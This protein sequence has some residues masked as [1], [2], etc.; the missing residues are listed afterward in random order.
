MDR[1]GR[2]PRPRALIAAARA[3]AA[4]L[5]LAFALDPS[6]RHGWSA[7]YYTDVDRERVELTRTT[8]HRVAFPNMHRPF[9]RVVQGWPMDRLGVPE[10]LPDLDVE[11]TADV[12]VPR[13]RRVLL[14]VESPNRTTLTVDGEV[15]ADQRFA[16]GRHRVEVRWQAPPVSTRAAA[17]RVRLRLLWGAHEDGLE[18]V[19]ASAIRPARGAWPPLRVALWISAL[20]G[21]LLWAALVAW[22]LWPGPG[23][24]EARRLAVLA[25]VG[26][27]VL[28]VAFRAFDYQVMPEFRDNADELF[29]TWNGFSLLTEGVPRGWSL[30]PGSYGPAVER[31]PVRFFG[32]ERTV[33]SPY[34]EHPPLLHVLVGAAAL[35]GG[36][37]HFLEAKLAHT[38]LVAIAMSALTL[39]LLVV[40]GRRLSPRGPAPY[41]AG[42]LYAVLPPIALQG[43]VVKEE[44]LLAPLCLAALLFFLRWRDDGRHRVDLVAA[45]ALMGLGILGKVPAV[46]WV[47]ALAMLV[48]AEGRMGPA[49]V[50]GGVGL[51]VATLWPLFGLLIDGPV[52][53]ETQRLQGGRPTHWNLFPRWFHVSLINHNLVGRGWIQFLWLGYVAGVARRGWRDGAV[54]TVPLVTYL[55]AI[56]VGAG[57]WTF[58]WYIAPLYP[59]LCLGAGMFLAELWER[60]TLLAGFLFVALAVFYALNFLVD[61]HW[62]KQPPA[63]PVLR[64]TIS[65]A[66]FA[67]FAP[68]ALVQVW[69]RHTLPLWLARTAT[70]ASLALLVVASGLFVARYDVVFETH[71]NFDRDSYFDR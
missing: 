23:R 68:Y 3:A 64:R 30:W 37:D 28:G 9:A 27:L 31:T 51:A 16:P 50:A 33:I 45:A 29:A 46:V 55:A 43:R 47:P 63:W 49:W 65:L 14:R 11:L 21:A 6:L 40:L 13:D 26:L 59:L 34:F 54:L 41:L 56:S 36:A 18:A 17:D 32:E 20:L 24:A 58:G 66:A 61:V 2:D 38:R 39:W 48:A 60:P 57:N 7:T 5:L 44:L 4:W 53:V 10:E 22:A 35:A 70:V 67:L 42:L 12:V 71:R 19:P 1:R 15:A 62:A 8:E 25:T 52:F 69:P